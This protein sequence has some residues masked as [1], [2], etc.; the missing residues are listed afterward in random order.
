MLHFVSH[1]VAEAAGWGGVLK[2]IDSQCRRCTCVYVLTC[3]I[4]SK[5]NYCQAYIE[6]AQYS[7]QQNIVK[8][9][10]KLELKCMFKKCDLRKHLKVALRLFDC[11]NG[12]MLGK[13]IDIVRVQL[14]SHVWCLDRNVFVCA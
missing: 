2:M 9:V 5:T 3:I 10:D 6:P 11:R 12:G 1:W 13:V 14:N 7:S 8:N 4:Q